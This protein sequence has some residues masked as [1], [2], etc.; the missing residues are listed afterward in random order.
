MSQL[1]KEDCMNVRKWITAT[2][3]MI[4][5]KLRTPLSQSEIDTW[6][7]IQSIDRSLPKQGASV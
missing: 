4:E 1:T 7:K 2:S 3:M 5:G 6:D